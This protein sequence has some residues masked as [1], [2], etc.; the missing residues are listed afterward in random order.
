M[1][2]QEDKGMQDPSY[3]LEIF[4]I[5]KYAVYIEDEKTYRKASRMLSE[6]MHVYVTL[7]IQKNGVGVKG[8]DFLPIHIDQ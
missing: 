4:D 8:L 1:Q 7:A 6:K 3:F 2:K 5:A